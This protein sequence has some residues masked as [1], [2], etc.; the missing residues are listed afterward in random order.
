M[1]MMETDDLLNRLV[2]FRFERNG[3]VYAAIRRFAM[4]KMQAREASKKISGADPEKGVDK[5]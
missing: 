5:E 4:M 1:V 2:S 3:L